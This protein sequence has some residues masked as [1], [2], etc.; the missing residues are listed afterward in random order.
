MI[1]YK[2]NF[3]MSPITVTFYFKAH[4]RDKFSQ[5][6]NKTNRFLLT[7]FIWVEKI[8]IFSSNVLNENLFLFKKTKLLQKL[9]LYL[10][11]K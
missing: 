5:G 1:N 9:Q 6:I 8:N 11:E 3:K 2:I 7:L 10:C 4:A